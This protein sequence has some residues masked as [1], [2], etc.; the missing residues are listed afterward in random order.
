VSRKRWLLVA[1]SFFAAIAMSTAVVWRG[2]RHDGNTP[3][4]PWYVHVAAFLVFAFEVLARATKVQWG[5]KA[6]R[7]P[8]RWMTAFRVSVGGDFGASI[9]PSRAGAEPARFLMLAE[10]GVSTGPALL[11]L[12]FE[13]ALE[14]VSLVVVCAILAVFTESGA[15]AGGMIGVIGGYALFLIGVAVAAFVI[16]SRRTIGPPPRWLRLLGI[17]AGRWRAIRRAL[18]HVRTGM[19]GLRRARP[20]AMLVAFALSMAHVALRIAMLPVIVLGSGVSAP[21]TPLIVWPLLLLY[22]GALAPAPAGGGAVEFAFAVGL[23]NVLGP[24]ELAG[25][26]VWWRFY[27]FYIYLI[28]GAI[29]AGTTVLRAINGAAKKSRRDPSPPLHADLG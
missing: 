20:G 16:A 13:L 21:W 26:L 3:V 22:G 5:A 17:H 27:S 1:L 15:L 18:R 19:D 28:A 2:W 10:G 6:L 23:R 11:I 4:L 8:L 25:A 24:S 7:I 12:F 29:V 14:L 9:T